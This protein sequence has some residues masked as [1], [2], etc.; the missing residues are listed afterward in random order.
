MFEDLISE[1]TGSDFEETPVDI[2]T[3]VTSPEYLNLATP[4]S[5][6]QYQIIKVSTQIYKKETLLEIYGEEEGIKRW[7]QTYKEIVA[8]LGKGNLADYQKFYSVDK[9]YGDSYQINDGFMA[10]SRDEVRPA[11]PFHNEGPDD[12]YRVTTK[13][14]YYFD[15]GPNHK[16]PTWKRSKH[17]KYYS[18]KKQPMMIPACDLQQGDLVEIKIGWS[19]PTNQYNVSPDEARLIG[20]MI[21]DGSFVRRQKKTGTDSWTQ[22]NAKFT[23]STPEVQKDFVRIV[24]SMGGDVTY[25][26][27]GKGRW[28]VRVIGI[29]KRFMEIGIA[30][31]YNQKKPWNDEWISMSNSNMLEIV[32]GVY[33]TDG[34][35]TF[36]KPKI[37]GRPITSQVGIEINSE[38]C[39]KGIHL[40]LLKC[41]I[42]SKFSLHRPE[43]N[44]GKHSAT[45]RVCITDTSVSQLWAE[46][47]QNL[48]GKQDKIDRLLS[49]EVAGLRKN[50]KYDAVASVEYIGHFPVTVCTSVAVEEVINAG[51]VITCN[52][53]K[54]FLSTIA[55]AYV[56]Y[57]ILCLKDP[58]VY[59][60]KP[61]GDSI[62]IIN[63]AINA[64]QAL[65]VFF[66]GFKNRIKQ[67]PWFVGKYEE[68]MGEFK[69]IKNV[70]VYSGHSEREAWEGYN[71][72]FCVLD[73]ISGFALDSST[74]NENSK[75]AAAIFKMY[76]AS[77]TSRF[78][79]Y[80]KLILLSFPRYKDDFIMQRYN[81]ALRGPNNSGVFETIEREHTFKINE[82][83]DWGI[84][85]NEFTIRW[86]EDHIL[87]YGSPNTFAM[88][89]PSWEVNPTRNI[90]EYKSDFM[91]DPVDSLGRY[92]C[93]P[94]E[95]VDAFFKSREKV[96]TAFVTANGI[97]DEGRF[98]EDFLPVDDETQY[99]VHVDLARKHDRCAVAMA[100]VDK[101]I[102]RDIGSQMT[103][104]A[105]VVKVD[106]IKWWTP[107]SDKHVD[108]TEVRNFVLSLQ[109][110]GFNLK[111]VTFDRW[112][113]TDISNE[114]RGYGIKVERLSVAKRHYTDLAMVIHEERV[115]GPN[116]SIL[117]NE[118]LQLRVTANDKIDHPRTAT[119]GK[120]L[121]DAM[122]GAVY[123][124]IAHT[125]RGEREI[126]IVTVDSVRKDYN[127]GVTNEGVIRRP[128]RDVGQYGDRMPEG[129][130][131]YMKMLRS[132]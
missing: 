94:P 11:D 21:G 127:I 118:I 18:I 95:A 115:K 79:D 107:T 13:H 41:G 76:R 23:N 111:I 52:S 98:Y 83:L 99:F 132:I 89:R 84:E 59:Y 16:T 121:S 123:N 73:E 104:V 14:G 32:K 82:E 54:D 57:L 56:T 112:E 131:A 92:A 50:D 64:K 105:P 62:D 80:G 2:E 106:L 28:Q 129:I 47:I 17:G 1:L 5:D 65:N 120:D 36:Q 25:T 49:I 128:D 102:Q 33:A 88:K 125:P 44:D 3:F 9:G 101:F 51:G 35:I 91:D 38:S 68:K 31:E 6:L 48:P 109:Q 30:H 69:F 42:I 87:S 103:E 24:K 96:E 10:D 108:F 15:C 114:I 27:S 19:E 75:T 46:K 97:D 55:C 90:E 8:C 110:R 113:S 67:S 100:H 93:Q 39:A 20:Y 86:N 74:G 77:L 116:I 126:E 12:I 43:R 37:K 40:A 34:W 29:N 60:G 70:N 58:A 61:P 119:G 72:I 81:R 71:V 22:S 85:G 122:C 26:Q 66:A 53:G 124:A 130:D 117:M 63:V 7:S 4:L 45:Y 78:P